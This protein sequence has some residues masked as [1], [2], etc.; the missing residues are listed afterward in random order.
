MSALRLYKLQMV[1]IV[2]AFLLSACGSSPQESM[3]S[4]AV[5]QTVQAGQSLTKVAELPTNTPAAP[6][7]ALATFA[8]TPEITP[9]SSPASVSA[10]ADPNCVK[11]SLITENPP[12]QTILTPGEYFWK[13]WTLQNIGTCTW[14]T[15][16]KLVFW[17]GDRLGSSIS[18]PLPDDVA[19][20]EKKD[21]SIY[22][23][24]P[25]SGGTFTGYWRL[26]T[27]WKSNF[28]VGQYDSPISTSI[29]VGSITP[30]SKKTETVFGVTSVT[31]TVDRRCAPAN[32][33]YTITAHISSNGPV[34]AD[35][36]WMQSDG[37][38]DETNT[39]T[40]T[41]AATKSISREWS[42]KKE[43][44]PNP[45]WVQ[46]IVTSPTYQ[47]FDKVILPDQCYFKP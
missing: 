28:G 11:A 45:R 36:M 10:P 35:F 15:S 31:Y 38:N 27:P 23:Q 43:S 22:L 6:T 14:T 42:Q 4:T 39:V 41:K 8:V 17:D 32:T 26:Q 1:V 19:P 44:S 20:N 9:T 25:A 12:D 3:I 5:A 37:N 24:A 2:T 47:E 13:T 16:Y 21:I 7:E 46:I 40:F 33:F 30:V 34:E 29:V 18:Y